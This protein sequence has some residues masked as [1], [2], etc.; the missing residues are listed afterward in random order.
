MLF[1]CVYKSE[2]YMSLMFF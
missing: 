1:T 2:K